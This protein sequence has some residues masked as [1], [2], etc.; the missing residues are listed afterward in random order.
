[1]SRKLYKKS[2]W[3]HKYF[4][5]ILIFFLIEMS[6]SGIILNHKEVFYKYDMPSFLTPSNYDIKNFSRSAIIDF[7]KKDDYYYIAGKKGVYRAKDEEELNFK[8][9]FDGLSPY[10]LKRKSYDLQEIKNYIFLATED[11]LYYLKSGEETWKKI[12]D[13]NEVIKKTIKKDDNHLFVFSE[14]N[15][16]I[17]DVRSLKI[18]KITPQREG[19]RFVTAV[20]VFFHM[21]DGRIWGLPGRILFDFMGLVIIFLSVSAFYMWYIPK[22]INK[23]KGNLKNNRKFYRFFHKYHKK[24]GVYTFIF[25]III[26][27]TAIFMRPPFIAAITDVIWPRWTYLSKIP[28]NPWEKRIENGLYDKARNK[29]IIQTS[30][31][32]WEWNI[33]DD[34]FSEK[35]VKSKQKWPL[36]IMGATYLETDEDNNYIMGS[37]SGFFKFY[38]EENKYVNLVKTAD[39]YNRIKPDKEAMV[40]GAFKY[41]GKYYI[42]THLQGLK[43]L[44]GNKAVLFKQPKIMNDIKMP[45]WNWNFELHNGRIFKF[46]IGKYYIILVPFSA[47]F[48]FLVMISG[49]YDWF[50]IAVKSKKSKKS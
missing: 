45:L 49:L 7:I 25:V 20:E 2:K 29:L 43:D 33:R 46:I 19:R 48:F 31:Y 15:I 4:G 9:L 36:F 37:F 35:A 34:D 21:H 13:V 5:L 39:K 12:F 50:F 1:M 14:S 32:L 42:A 47:V 11:G 22:K 30:E 18:K 40:A 44:N 26:S 24:I 16:Y 41:K 27:F 8:P 38:P 3:Y 17:L 28:E 23:R 10:T 6:V